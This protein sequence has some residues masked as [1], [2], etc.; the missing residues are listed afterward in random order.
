MSARRAIVLSGAVLLALG[1]CPV[2]AQVTNPETGTTWRV[3]PVYVDDT[4]DDTIGL[5]ALFQTSQPHYDTRPRFPRARYLSAR[6]H[7]V[8][9]FSELSIPQ[10]VEASVW[11]GGSVSFSERNPDDP[12]APLDEAPPPYKFDH[13]FF[14]YGIRA[15]YESSSD[16][17]EQAAAGGIE[18]RYVDPNQPFIP[19]T[20]V[21]FD[22]V[23]P[24]ASEVRD[25]L[26]I[27]KDSYGRLGLRGYWLVPL[28]KRFQTELDGGYF[29]AFGLEE[30]LQENG[31][32]DG[33]YGSATVGFLP[34][35]PI[36]VLKIESLLV[37][38]AY[39]NRPTG[40]QEQKAWTVGVEIG[41][42]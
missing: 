15:Q 20:L 33:P 26:D 23:Q 28:G 14:G 1:G 25:A 36:W 18:L 4:H 32:S 21:Q 38:Y 11:F 40:P 34:G 2:A 10:N 19:S 16:F 7:A 29:W 13:G 3:A 8:V 5:A 9:P 39:G 41:S 30:A 17:D 37:G 42:R 35:W 22:W 12:D 6:M 31:W 24:I 27:S